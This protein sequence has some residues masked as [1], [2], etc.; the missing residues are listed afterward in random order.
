M[1]AQGGLRGP[2]GDGHKAAGSDRVAENQPHAVAGAARESHH[3]HC[4]QAPHQGRSQPVF[5][6]VPIIQMTTITSCFDRF[7]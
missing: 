4:T 2:R 6:E 5:E 7:E 3:L 1:N